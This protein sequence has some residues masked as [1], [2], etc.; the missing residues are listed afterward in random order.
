MY[1]GNSFT[2]FNVDL[3]TKDNYKDLC[4]NYTELEDLI[5]NNDPCDDVNEL[6]ETLEDSAEF[7]NGEYDFYE[8][9]DYVVI[10]DTLTNAYYFYMTIFDTEQ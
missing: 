4:G 8:F 10:N 2:I 5:L 1:I 6:L 9:G 3:T 7:A